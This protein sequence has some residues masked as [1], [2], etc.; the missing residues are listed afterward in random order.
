M[1]KLLSVIIIAA[2]L[3]ML[4]L[5]ASAAQYANMWELWSSWTNSKEPD[6]LSFY[7]DYICGVW[8]KDGGTHL[9]VMVTKDEAGEAGKAEILGL[10]EDDS[11]VDF[12]YGSYT[13][14]ELREL[15][16]VIVGFMKEN[17][18]GL[19]GCGVEEKNNYL[20]V[21]IDKNNENAQTFMDMCFEKYNNMIA[22]EHSDGVSFFVANEAGNGDLNIGGAAPTIGINPSSGGN[23]YDADSAPVNQYRGVLLWLLPALALLLIAGTVLLIL[24]RRRAALV[25]NTGAVVNGD[26]PLTRAQTEAAVKESEAI[27]SPELDRRIMDDIEKH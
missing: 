8:S 21:M 3:L 24:R 2:S 26:A 20:S 19:I 22:F 1:K 7:P 4:C 18:Y 12:T 16:E 27:P 6:A 10:I 17:K 11:S 5:P 23:V 14:L 15:Q 13:Y 9:T 25:T